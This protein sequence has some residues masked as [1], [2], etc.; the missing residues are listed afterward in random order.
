MLLLFSSPCTTYSTELSSQLNPDYAATVRHSHVKFKRFE[1]LKWD[2]V[3]GPNVGMSKCYTS[4]LPPGF[5]L[6]DIYLQWVKLCTS[7]CITNGTYLED[8]F[9]IINFKIIWYTWSDS[10]PAT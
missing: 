3:K 6:H 2:M 4:L 9:D 1:V 5:K 8:S 7:T 10:L